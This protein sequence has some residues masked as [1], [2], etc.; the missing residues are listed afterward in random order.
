MSSAE[1]SICLSATLDRDYRSCC[2]IIKLDVPELTGY[3]RIG[4]YMLRIGTGQVYL[5]VTWA[6]SPL[7]RPP[8]LPAKPLKYKT[9]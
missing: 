8:P 3:T 7:L 9:Y 5:I 4:L 6:N 2:I 1:S